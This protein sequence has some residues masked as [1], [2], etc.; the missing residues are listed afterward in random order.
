MLDLNTLPIFFL[1]ANTVSGYVSRFGDCLGSETDWHV[2]VLK[3]GPGSGKSTFMK[4]AAQKLAE[5]NEKLFLAPCPADPNSLDAVVCESR[6]LMILDGTSPH[7]MDPPL[8]GIGGAIADTGRFWNKAVLLENKEKIASLTAQNSRLHSRAASYIAAA[9]RLLGDNRRQALAHTDTAKLE[10]YAATLA[11]KYI[12]KTSG[13]SSEQVRFLSGITPSGV[14]YYRSTVNKLCNKVVEI[15][16]DYGASSELLLGHLR[17]AAL[18]RGHFVIN[19][20]CPMRPLDK[21]DH[22]LLP[23][24]GLAFCSVNRYL[25][26]GETDRRKIH[27]GRFTD[28]ESLSAHKSHLSFNRRAAKELLDC[29]VSLLADAKRIHDLL[30]QYYIDAMDY[31][32]LNAYCDSLLAEI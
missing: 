18:E 11:K 25:A 5:Q 23:E 27:F 6:K 16:D 24:L 8:P 19:C 1:G 14:V 13:H 10:K 15:W 12:P 9:G 4:K 17:R 29:A 30:E 31:P 32:S 20:R 21:T 3:G 28:T 7:P 2:T 26:S 22:L